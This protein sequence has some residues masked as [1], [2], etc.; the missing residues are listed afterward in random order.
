MGN[1]IQEVVYF[2]SDLVLSKKR[3][4]PDAI[5][6]TIKQ[7]IPGKGDQIMIFCPLMV[8]DVGIS[9]NMSGEESIL[10]T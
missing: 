7:L 6:L 3:Q 2:S 8:M 4:Y 10:F 9:G 5:P 1:T